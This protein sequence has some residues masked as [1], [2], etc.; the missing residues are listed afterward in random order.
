MCAGARGKFAAGR[1]GARSG[2][3]AAPAAPSRIEKQGG[4]ERRRFVVSFSP[5]F[6]SCPSVSAP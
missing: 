5:C 2:F 3:A 4:K 1:D 6:F